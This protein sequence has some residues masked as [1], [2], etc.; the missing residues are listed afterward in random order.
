MDG[1][2][3]EKTLAGVPALAQ[4]AMDT[5]TL[6]ALDAAGDWL[7]AWCHTAVAKDRDRF[8][9]DGKDEFS[10]SNPDGLLFHIITFSEISGCQ[11]NGVPTLDDTWFPGCAWSY[12]LCGECGVHLGWFYTG[13]HDFA[14]LIRDRIIRAVFVRN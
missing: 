3:A 1:K 14:G 10:F 13:Q 4:P 7:C 8:K 2:G 9:I 5:R 6:L 12:C 11:Q